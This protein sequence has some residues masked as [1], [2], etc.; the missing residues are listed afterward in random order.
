MTDKKTLYCFGS[1]MP[2]FDAFLPPNIFLQFACTMTD[3]GNHHLDY[4]VFHKCSEIFQKKENGEF[5][6]ILVVPKAQEFKWRQIPSFSIHD[7][8]DKSDP[9][10]S[11]QG[12]IVSTHDKLPESLLRNQKGFILHR[13]LLPIQFNQPLNTSNYSTA[14]SKVPSTYMLKSSQSLASLSCKAFQFARL[15]CKKVG[16]K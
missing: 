10:L 5:K 13:G 16:H 4:A 7:R 2:G 9:Q 1:N 8:I 11:S 6:F 14:A 3:R 12:S 15:I